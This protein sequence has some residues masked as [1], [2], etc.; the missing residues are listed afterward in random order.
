M[1]RFATTLFIALLTSG[2]AHAADTVEVWE[3]GAVDA[4]MYLGFDGFGGPLRDGET[5]SETVL[6]VGLLPR[7]SGF[8]ALGFA[9]SA[10]LD[11]SAHELAMGLFG[12]PV[13]TPH[14]DLD[15]FFTVRSAAGGGFALVPALEW[16]LDAA[17]ELAAWGLF[18]RAGMPVERV[19]TET[20][21]RAAVA[22]ELTAGAYWT[23]RPGHQLVA[24]ADARVPF[25][26][27][28]GDGGVDFGGLAL[29]YN[30]LLTDRFE[31]LTQAFVDV[32]QGSEPWGAGLMAG[33]IATIPTRKVP[34]GP[35]FP[36]E[37][38]F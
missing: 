10:G 30:V 29:G 37:G 38:H 8:V 14:T 33:F 28:A 27:P 3:F 25:T 12:T 6:G 31:L 11:E 20:E 18:L 24:E 32:P 19:T 34:V 22:G 16:N 2:L 21:V 5:F 1:A 13:D 9:A 35:S 36:A 23:L 7:L 26:S 17:P 15:L 4:E